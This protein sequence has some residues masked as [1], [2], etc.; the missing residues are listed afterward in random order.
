MCTSVHTQREAK[1]QI[2][3]LQKSLEDS[4]ALVS[5]LEIDLEESL[6]CPRLKPGQAL[7]RY[8]NR[9]STS[10]GGSSHRRPDEVEEMQLTDILLDEG[11]R[12]ALAA[13]DK[14]T[15][16]NAVVGGGGKKGGAKRGVRAAGGSLPSPTGDYAGAGPQTQVV[17]ILQ[18]QR[19]RYKERLVKVRPL[20][21]RV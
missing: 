20:R 12:G 5:R 16:G 6:R 9:D 15:F 7:S 3:S 13:S 19:D 2:A 17:A 18:A 4:A 14:N 21:S 10:S 1:D 8:S 11:D